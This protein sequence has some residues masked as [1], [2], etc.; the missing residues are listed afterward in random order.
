M[1][2]TSTFNTFNLVNTEESILPICDKPYH[3]NTRILQKWEELEHLW[4]FALTFF[5]KIIDKCVICYLY[6]SEKVWKY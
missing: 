2:Y 3:T 6:F 5:N 4:N 1:T